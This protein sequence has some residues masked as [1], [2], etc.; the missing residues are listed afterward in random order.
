MSSALSSLDDYS[1]AQIE[2]SIDRLQQGEEYLAR[3]E[4]AREQQ[5]AQLLELNQVIWQLHG[6][7]NAMSPTQKTA[8][9][10]TVVTQ[11]RPPPMRS[12]FDGTTSQFRS[13]RMIIEDRLTSDCASLTPRQQWI[14]INDSLADS[15]EKGSPIT[16]SPGRL[17]IGTPTRSSHTS[18]HSVPTIRRLLWPGWSC[19]NSDSERPNR[20]RSF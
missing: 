4:V 5:G 11:P 17:P 15:V 8:A 10:N 14:C 1:T 16:S 2:V 20:P 9:A 12:L 18:K 6:A 13:W 7:Q 19:I 3:S